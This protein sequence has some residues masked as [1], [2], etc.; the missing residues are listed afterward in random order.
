M[1]TIQG[2][3]SGNGYFGRAWDPEKQWGSNFDPHPQPQNSLL[4][5]FRLQPGLEWKFLLRRTWLRQNCSYCSFQ[6]FHSLS[7]GNQ[8]SLVRTFLSEPGSKSKK[9]QTWGLGVEKWSW[10]KAETFAGYIRWRIRWEVCGQFSQ[11]SPDPTKTQ[12][13]SA[14]RNLEIKI[15]STRAFRNWPRNLYR[16][17]PSAQNEHSP[18]EP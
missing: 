14:L 3:N 6:D 10:N 1:L 17:V 18:R 4:R 2:V 11:N 7:K 15:S 12:P 16:C 13:K 5:I 9:Q 8:V